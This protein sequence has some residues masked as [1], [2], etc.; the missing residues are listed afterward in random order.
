[1]AV[2]CEVLGLPSDNDLQSYRITVEFLR[3]SH[4]PVYLK[5][6]NAST[7]DTDFKIFVLLLRLIKLKTVGVSFNLS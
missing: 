2:M 3:Q 6:A 4:I 1:M 5:I 7:T